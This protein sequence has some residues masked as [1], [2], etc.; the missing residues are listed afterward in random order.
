MPILDD[1]RSALY[2][3]G[4]GSSARTRAAIAT[5]RQEIGRLKDQSVGA[6]QIIEFLGKHVSEQ[7]D[8]IERLRAREQTAEWVGCY[9][10][11]Q[12]AVNMKRLPEEFCQFLLAEMRSIEAKLPLGTIDAWPGVDEQ[13]PPQQKGDAR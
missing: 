6:A 5:A 10:G 7:A 9:F 4:P 2:D 1:L 12:R 3:R 8:E 13:Q 11:I